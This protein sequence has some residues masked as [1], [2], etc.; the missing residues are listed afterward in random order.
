MD[1]LDEED[2]NATQRKLYTY[3]RGNHDDIDCYITINHVLVQKFI[4]DDPHLKKSILQ[5]YHGCPRNRQ[6]QSN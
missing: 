5:K 6:H 2:V 3:C 1:D 4:A